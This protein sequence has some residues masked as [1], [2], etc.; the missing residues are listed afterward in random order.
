MLLCD[1]FIRMPGNAIS[2]EGI[3]FNLKRREEKYKLSRGQIKSIA[4][5]H[6]CLY[7]LHEVPYVVDWGFRHP[8]YNLFVKINQVK[9]KGRSAKKELNELNNSEISDE[10]AIMD[11]ICASETSSDLE[12]REKFLLEATLN[13]KTEKPLICFESSSQDLTNF[14]ETTEETTFD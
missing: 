4:A 2:I 3:Y 6:G 11:I 1:D 13:K 9:Y 12:R 8:D 7:I 5:G 10:Q 14:D